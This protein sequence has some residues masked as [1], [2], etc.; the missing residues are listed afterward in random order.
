MPRTEFNKGA[1]VKIVLE[2][3]A[4]ARSW[5]ELSSVRHE[6]TFFHQ[7]NGLDGIIS[8]ETVDGY[9]VELQDG[10]TVTLFT[11]ELETLEAN[12]A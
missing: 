6:L 2:K 10:R 11:H 4:P 5:A 8:Y 9:K 3:P 12:A 7:N 1:R